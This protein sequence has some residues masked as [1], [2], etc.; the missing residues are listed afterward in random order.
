VK[1]AEKQFTEVV[2]LIQAMGPSAQ[3]QSKNKRRAARTAIRLSVKIKSENGDGNVPWS[4][5]E[6][7]D[8]SGRGVLLATDQQMSAGNSFLICLPTKDGLS[9]KPLICR[10]AHCTPQ[11]KSN[12]KAG[13]MIGAEFI[14]RLDE[15][16]APQNAAL[17]DEQER[18]RRSILD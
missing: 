5:A 13:F 11:S 6:L 17:S 16:S 8:L 3:K 18:I 7:R 9:S 14:G 1:F 2:E 12:P 4:I 15:V 10:V